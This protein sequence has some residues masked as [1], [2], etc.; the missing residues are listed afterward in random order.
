ML[1]YDADRF[2]PSMRSRFRSWRYL[3]SSFAPQFRAL[4]ADP[5]SFAEEGRFPAIW[6]TGTKFV[7]L[8]TAPDGSRAVYKSFRPG[9]PVFR[10]RFRFAP[11]TREAMNYRL[12]GD[13]GIPTPE[14]LAA[15]ETR[16]AGRLTGA[17]LI[18]RYAENFTDGRIFIPGGRLA[19]DAEA[20]DAFTLEHLRLLAKMHDA[21]CRN[22]G[23]YPANLLIGP[24]DAAP[25]ALWIDLAGCGRFTWGF[26]LKPTVR[27]LTEYFRCFHFDAERL[28]KFVRA[29]LAARRHDPPSE[30]TL[31]AAVERAMRRRKF[32]HMRQACAVL[33]AA[34]K[35]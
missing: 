28:R 13:L 3:N 25:R 26:R 21:G 2:D 20:V 5:E 24:P 14:L 33:T 9:A 19:D 8:L 34:E 6:H 27:D 22:K 16:S 23:F 32:R 7:L 29:Y 30:E 10:K 35:N 15:G 4:A 12:V 1:E 17:F 18:T 31:T 11:T